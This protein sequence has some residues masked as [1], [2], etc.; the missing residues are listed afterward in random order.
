MES[1]SDDD[2]DPPYWLHRHLTT[3]LAP[4]GPDGQQC[5]D[6]IEQKSGREKQRWNEEFL[7]ECLDRALQISNGPT[8]LPPDNV[9]DDWDAKAVRW[10]REPDKDLSRVDKEIDIGQTYPEMEHRERDGRWMVLEN[11]DQDITQ[12]LTK[13]TNLPT[14]TDVHN[15]PDLKVEYWR[16]TPNKDISGVDKEIAIG[17]TY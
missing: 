4:H 15:D 3:A 13:A 1:T 2:D 7:P 10:S 6:Y 12:S 8:K 16:S 5:E 11:E 9:P 17:Q 14:A